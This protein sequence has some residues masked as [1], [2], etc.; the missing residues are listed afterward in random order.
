MV[1]HTIRSRHLAA[2]GAVAALIL[3]GALAR[4]ALAFNPQPDPPGFG[5]VGIA[6]G[7]SALISLVNLGA[8]DASGTPAACAAQL[9]FFNAAGDVIASREV[10][11]RAGHAAS[12]AFVPDFGVANGL[13]ND[14]PVAPQ[15]A[16]IRGAINPL[17]S[18]PQSC[19]ASVE[20]I[21]TATSRTTILFP[22]G[23]C[24]GTLC[25]EE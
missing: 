25:K 9:Q 1:N 15:R 3:V 4:T 22:P 11:L 6:E 8:P 17:G 2:G 14:G 7:Q 24:R 23:P 13:A 18:Y 19:K 10:K 12:L 16:Q 5:M 20:V 21:D